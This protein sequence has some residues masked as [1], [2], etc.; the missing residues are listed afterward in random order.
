MVFLLTAI[1]LAALAVS[2]KFLPERAVL[3]LW[4]K[5]R[6]DT[7]NSTGALAADRQAASRELA[8]TAAALFLKV[9]LDFL[10]W[11]FFN[12]RSPW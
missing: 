2:V 4:G 3:L 9:V 7:M 8:V 11:S 6:R 1:L 12:A 10:L 5:R